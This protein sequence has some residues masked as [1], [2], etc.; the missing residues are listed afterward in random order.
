MLRLCSAMKPAHV[1]SS[2][3]RYFHQVQGHFSL[4]DHIVEQFF[5]S[6]ADSNQNTTTSA[7]NSPQQPPTSTPN[8]LDFEGLCEEDFMSDAEG[9]QEQ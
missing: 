8:N 4:P 3:I 9:E 6:R 7:Q 2:I 5:A 1:G